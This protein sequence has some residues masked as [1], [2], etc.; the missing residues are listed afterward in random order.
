MSE[1]YND[2]IQLPVGLRNK[3]I[4]KI[5]AH[6]YRTCVTRYDVN[7][8]QVKTTVVRAGLPSKHEM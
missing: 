8:K 7:I 4:Y 5:Y 6:A 1:L 3:D 2:S